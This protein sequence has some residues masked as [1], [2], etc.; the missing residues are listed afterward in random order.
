MEAIQ[1]ILMP[2]RMIRLCTLFVA[3]ALANGCGNADA[4]TSPPA[5]VPAGVAVSPA[6]VELDALGATVK[7]T[8]EVMDQEGRV[9]ADATVTWGSGDSTVATVDATGLVTAAGNG[10]ATITASAG[11][12]SGGTLVLA[13]ATVSAG[14]C[15]R[16]PQVRDAITEEAGKSDCAAVT[17]ADLASITSLNLAGP[18][19]AITVSDECRESYGRDIPAH[20]E[21]IVRSLL[22]CPSQV[23]SGDQT[24]AH[25][26]GGPEL[27]ALRDGDFEGLS[28]LSR[29]DL[30]DN[31]LI[32]LPEDLF[33]PLESLTSVDLSRNILTEL[34]EG[35]FDNL[36]QLFSVVVA[37]NR[38][39]ELPAGFL[40]AHP[41]LEYVSVSGN[42]LT[43]LPEG[44]LD[45]STTLRYAYFSS[46]ELTELPA[47]FPRR[48]PRA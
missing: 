30:Q 27:H 24:T 29:L 45:R 2:S 40:S 22:G 6:T 1:L 5:P 31:W 26:S 14:V 33:D 7:L 11:S 37:G 47:G 18:R 41:E 28:G 19:K 20:K 35:L 8:A 43:G 25:S 15:D 48:A 38:L 12:A 13:R 17:S 4:P 23:A 10:E 44:F 16:T 3:V 36:G 39:S 21:V 42:R 32:E 9:M 34:P 46:N